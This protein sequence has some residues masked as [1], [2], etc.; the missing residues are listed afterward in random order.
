MLTLIPDPDYENDRKYEVTIT[1]TDPS[2]DYGM[3]NV[4][5]NITD[6]NEPP[7][8]DTTAGLNKKTLLYA[9]NGTDTVGMYKATDPD[10]NPKP[11]I[12]Y[13]LVTSPEPAAN[14]PVVD[15]DIADN[16]L[17]EITNVRGNGYFIGHLR[18]KE[19]PNYE[20]P[21]DAEGGDNVYH[22]A[23]RADVSDGTG[24][25]ITRVVRVIVTNVN[26]AP[27]FSED[28]DDLTIS[29]NPDD[30]QKQPPLAATELYL[31]NRGVGK[32][33]ENLPAAPNLDVG[34]P[35][36][37]RDDDNTFVTQ[38]YT[39]LGATPRD[40]TLVY[41]P[42]TRPVQLI[43]G[44]TYTL[45]G[46]DDE[47]FHVVPATGQIL[48]LKKLDYENKSEHNV[49]VTATDPMGLY[50]HIDLT[51]KVLNVDEVPIS[52]VTGITVLG[53]DSENYPENGTGDVAP[54]PPRAR[55][56]TTS[57]GR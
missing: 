25:Y 19:S 49:R 8:W 55:T 53:P 24:D 43:D 16:D 6:D 32:P 38:N 18:F 35:M 34:I 36:V 45:S 3:V 4:V 14:V 52:T 7:K 27:V 54:T 41:G 11:G 23:V 26:E 44:L 21:Q 5:V 56:R 13:A 57:V 42:T 48:T 33:A 20:D 40:P 29:E 28:M 39:T 9:E 15:G 50:S 30:P 10:E 12:T 51:I 46:A 22:V 31:L 17:F 1:A 37:A 47:N 2:G